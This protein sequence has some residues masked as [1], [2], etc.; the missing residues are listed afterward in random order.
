MLLDRRAVD[1]RA[2]GGPEVFQKGIVEYGHHTRVLAAHCQIFNLDVILRL[3]SDGYALFVEWKFP[4]HRPIET[5][6]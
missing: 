3:A 2:V 1:Q 6:Y 4:D 5:E